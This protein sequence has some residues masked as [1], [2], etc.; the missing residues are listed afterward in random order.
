MKTNSLAGIIFL[1]PNT[2][3]CVS[4][5]MLSCGR[6][7]DYFR[8]RGA[9]GSRVL[10]VHAQNHTPHTHTPQLDGTAMRLHE[11]F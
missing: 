6:C 11:S 2:A 3:I 7:N 1:D 5:G 10:W 9:H 4:H 8:D